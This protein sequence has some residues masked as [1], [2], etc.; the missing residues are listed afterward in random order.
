MSIFVLKIEILFLNCIKN[1][2]VVRQINLEKAYNCTNLKEF[3]H[4]VFP[5]EWASIGAR[6][7]ESGAEF[8][9]NCDKFAPRWTHIPL[10]NRISKSGDMSETWLKSIIFRVHDC[11]HQLWGLPVPRVFNDEERRQFKR[12]W[13]CAEVSVLTITEF[14]Y[15]HWLYDTQPH[16]KVFLEKRNTLMF[17]GTTALAH[18]NPIDLATRLDQLLHKKIK[19][20]WVR[21]NEYARKF[22]DDYVPMLE[23]DRQNIDHNWKLL[24][25]QKDKSY[26]NVLPNQRYAKDFD[27]LELTRWMITDFYHLMDTDSQIDIELAKFNHERRCKVNL[28][29]TWN[30]PPKLL[31][32]MGQDQQKL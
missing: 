14:I 8:I 6:I 27:G 22:I 12:M 18:K 13:M 20:D 19:P 1:M 26:L 2:S 28:P 23:Q 25:E 4:E 29:D 15:C 21:E 31:E 16:L 7:I 11:L 32:V 5:E 3:I 24:V 17:Q 30:N 10:T 9:E